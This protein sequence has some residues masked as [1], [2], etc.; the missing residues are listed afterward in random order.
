MVAVELGVV[1]D[2]AVVVEVWDAE[3][4]VKVPEG[5]VE[6]VEELC[7]GLVLKL[8]VFPPP[9]MQPRE[10]TTIPTTNRASRVFPCIISSPGE[11]GVGG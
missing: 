5:E 10:N 9:P 11:V 3:V 6:A 4:C 8:P 2:E 1:L 7:T